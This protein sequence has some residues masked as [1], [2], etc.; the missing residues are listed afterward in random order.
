MTCP[1]PQRASECDN[2][3]CRRNGC[4]GRPP[5]KRGNPNLSFHDARHPAAKFDDA[6]V[7]RIRRR[8]AEGLTTGEIGAA[9]D[10]HPDTIRR[11]VRRETYASVE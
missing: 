5:A 3:S 6:T 10:S 7:R 4:F 2:H 9:L 11:I 8:Y 1:G